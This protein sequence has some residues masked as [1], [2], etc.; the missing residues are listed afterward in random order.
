LELSNCSARK[1]APLPTD[2]SLV[3]SFAAQAAIAVENAEL[4]TQTREG[5]DQQA[6]AAEVLQIINASPDDLG[7]VFEA[8]L[9]NASRLCDAISGMLWTYDGKRFRT[10]ASR[11]LPAKY[12]GFRVAEDTVY[13][14]GTSPARILDG[15]RV[16]HIAD[17]ME[18]DLY[19]MG[20]RIVGLLWSLQEPAAF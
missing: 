10:V 5:L 13:T 17:L 3:Q 9:E 2:R 12:A 4:I 18:T 14:P 16:V 19:K 8:I 11:E 7:P 6:A 15:E 1:S 20:T